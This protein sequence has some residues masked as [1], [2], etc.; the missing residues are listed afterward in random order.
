MSSILN[1]TDL[2]RAYTNTLAVDGVSFAV[3]HKEIVGLVGPNGAGKTT[4]TETN[5][6]G[7]ASSASPINGVELVTLRSPRATRR[8]QK[9][10]WFVKIHVFSAPI[11]MLRGFMT[12]CLNR[13]ASPCCKFAAARFGV[14]PPRCSIP[15]MR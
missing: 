4:I 12:K 15:K 1:V 5:L 2:T 10:Y 3:A 14:L 11:M 7:S 9:I 8:Y 6:G 13:I